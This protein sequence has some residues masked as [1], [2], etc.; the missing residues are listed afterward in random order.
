M[1]IM[2]LYGMENPIPVQ[3]TF[4]QPLAVNYVHAQSTTI[5]QNVVTV[6]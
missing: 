5:T 2:Y 1:L 6:G 3:I 4:F